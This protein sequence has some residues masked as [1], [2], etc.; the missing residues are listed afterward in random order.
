MR[1]FPIGYLGI[2]DFLES[3]SAHINLLLYTE[4]YKEILGALK[5]Y[6]NSE[7]SGGGRGFHLII[8][9]KRHY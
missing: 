7:V 2:F 8:T 1:I 3:M 6:K 9:E 5:I 4:S